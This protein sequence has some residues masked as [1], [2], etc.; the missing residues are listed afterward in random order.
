[1]KHSSSLQGTLALCALI[2]ITAGSSCKKTVEVLPPLPAL[3]VLSTTPGDHATEGNFDEQ[4]TA[5]LSASVDTSL[6][7]V[8]FT[9]TSDGL[10]VPG[11][12]VCSDSLVSFKPDVEL[13]AATPFAAR[14]NIISKIPQTRSPL[15]YSWTFTTKAPDRFR[16][17]KRSDEVTDFNRDGSRMV[18]I[19]DDLYSFGGWSVPE[20]S[21]SDV[22][23]SNGD[24]SLWKKLPDAPW[25]GRHVFGMAQLNK[26]TYVVGGDNLHS[27]FDVWKTLDG[28]NWTLLS[29]NILGNRIYYG[30]TTH[31]GYIYV[32][33]GSGY[34]DVWR[35]RDGIT[36]EMVADQVG[37]LKK[38][39][40]AGSL[41][42]FGGKLWMVCGGGSGG[43]TGIAR[44]EVWSSTDGRVWN[45]E[46]NFG[47]SER[48][49]T[50]VCVWD[51]KLWV[52]GG[53]SS[54]ESN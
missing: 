48:Y 4:I 34:D 42:S 22:Y 1:M 17:T 8:A 39:N 7:S 46:K 5:R 51:N 53:Y 18:Q 16:M 10:L 26:A 13:A 23:L 29:D 32:V 30:C 43:G 9:I 52:V 12:I 21:F 45:Q 49:Y 20:E 25:H 35:S 28:Q 14:L 47:G 36:W 24:L 50:D 27:V 33:G 37:F 31:N 6:Y 3:Q 2:A 11:Q 38:E 41:A 54:E 40:F 15:I 19:G 44:K